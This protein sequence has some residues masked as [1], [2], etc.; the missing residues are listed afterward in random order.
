M[1]SQPEKVGTITTTTTKKITEHYECAA[2][3]RTY[4]CPPQTVDVFMT[5]NPEGWPDQFVWRMKGVCIDACLV[6]LFGGVSYGPDIA[7]KE[8]IGKEGETGQSCYCY[9]VNTVEGLQLLPEY[10]WLK[11]EDAIKRHVADRYVKRRNGILTKY[12]ENH[13]NV[14]WIRQHAT[15]GLIVEDYI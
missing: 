2:W 10:D 3:H 4:E 6:S 8:A 1:T 9:H 7:G 12:D 13:V 5:R 15:P 11:D 14:E